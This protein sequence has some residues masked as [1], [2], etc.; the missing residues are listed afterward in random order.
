MGGIYKTASAIVAA[1]RDAALQSVL[2]V[3]PNPGTGVFSVDLGANLKAGAELTV[4][5]A[6]GR[7][8]KAQTLNAAT[9]GA[10]KLTLDLTGEKTGIYT[11]QIRTEAGIA[12]Q[13][14]ALN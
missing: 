9:V 10:R 6:L 2:S 1:S 8:V 12:T 5:D 13:K 4:S 7:R 14:V 11:L 3:Y